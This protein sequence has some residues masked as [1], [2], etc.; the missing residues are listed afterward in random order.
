M[1]KYLD[2]NTSFLKFIL[3]FI[4]ILEIRKESSEFLKYK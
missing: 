4:L 1:K 2:A 3:V